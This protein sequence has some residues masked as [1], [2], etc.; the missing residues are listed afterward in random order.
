MGERPWGPGAEYLFSFSSRSLA[1]LSLR[2]PSA[3]KELLL[4]R[5][6][7]IKTRNAQGR[8]SSDTEENILGKKAELNIPI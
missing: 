4:S 1:V 6:C 8:Q 3:L 5:S 7:K 2:G